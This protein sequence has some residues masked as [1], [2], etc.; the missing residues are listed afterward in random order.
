MWAL[1]I[2]KYWDASASPKNK[3]FH[4]GKIGRWLTS[5]QRSR[6]F[7]T[8]RMTWAGGQGSSPSRTAWRSSWT[9]APGRW[10]YPARGPLLPHQSCC[11]CCCCC[12]PAEA[13]PWV[14]WMPTAS[15]NQWVAQVEAGAGRSSRRG[16]VAAW[17]GP[18]PAG[19]APPP[20]AAKC[21]GSRCA[22]S[23][24]SS[25]S[26][27]C[28]PLC[29]CDFQP[30]TGRREHVHCKTMCM[31]V[32]MCT[33]LAGTV[34]CKANAKCDRLWALWEGGETQHLPLG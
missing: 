33:L 10:T 34:A 8:R 17:P 32:T 9:S 30:Q 22:A 19:V 12:P 20:S 3:V 16:R 5:W 15:G 29:H 2:C 31:S 13:P 11:F 14:E 18:P 24:S 25:S 26:S 28:V 7:R 4:W 6:R 1:G 23:S 27:S 21:C